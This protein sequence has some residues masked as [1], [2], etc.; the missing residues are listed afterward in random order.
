M[1]NRKLQD[2]L[3]V[4]LLFLLG[5]M[6][7]FPSCSSTREVESTALMERETSTNVAESKQSE[8]SE[9]I[10]RTAQQT[11]NVMVRDSVVLLV[12]NDTILKEVWRWRYRDRLRVDTVY[13]HLESSASTNASASI[14]SKE[15]A[16][17]VVEMT[18]ESSPSPFAVGWGWGTILL[19]L[20]AGCIVLLIW[21]LTRRNE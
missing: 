17:K 12:R 13:Y 4:L 6:L 9:Q 10:Q 11:D 14:E 15:L 21:K 7:L 3:F 2:Y 19:L 18:K 20:G 1:D 8:T 5:C 16:E